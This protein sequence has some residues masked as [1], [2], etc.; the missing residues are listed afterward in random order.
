MNESRH[1][2]LVERFWPGVTSAGADAAANRLAEAAGAYRAGTTRV[3]HVRT[4]L[5]P[6]DELVW[7]MVEAGSRDAVI[8]VT[9]IARYPVD[10]IS[11]TIM[12]GG[13]RR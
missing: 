4:G 8:A 5:V 9:T 12:V 10:R 11:E 7:S 2:F 13:K 6:E 3:R 1:L